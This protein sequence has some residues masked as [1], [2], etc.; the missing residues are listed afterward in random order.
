MNNGAMSMDS[1]LK[2]NTFAVLDSVSKDRQEKKRRSR[3]QRQR[4]MI[5][6]ALKHIGKED[7]IDEVLSEVQRQ[8]ALRHLKQNKK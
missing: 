5:I 2:E 7:K 1:H 6:L 3:E 4:E 8:K